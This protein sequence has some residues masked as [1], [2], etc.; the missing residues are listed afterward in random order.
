ML[1]LVYETY[2]I[3]DKDVQLQR[4]NILEVSVS[5]HLTKYKKTLRTHAATT[6]QD[7]IQFVLIMYRSKPPQHALYHPSSHQQ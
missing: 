6:I 7:F 1:N 2:I 4:K 3:M 5:N